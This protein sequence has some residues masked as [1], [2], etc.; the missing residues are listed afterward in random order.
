MPLKKQKSWKEKEMQL[1]TK[2][3]NF[4]IKLKILPKIIKLKSKS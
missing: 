2:L 1:I 3:I 4:K